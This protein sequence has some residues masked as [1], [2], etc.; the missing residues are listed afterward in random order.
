[1]PPRRHLLAVRGRVPV[2]VAHRL[3]PAGH[4]PGAVHGVRGLRGAELLRL[5]EPGRVRAACWENVRAVRGLRAR[6][7]A[8][9]APGVRAPDRGHA[10][11]HAHVPLGRTD[12]RGGL[13]L[14]R[15]R[16]VR[17]RHVCVS[18][19]GQLRRRQP[20][21]FAAKADEATDRGLEH[22]PVLH[23][24]A[25]PGLAADRKVAPNL[26]RGEL[27]GRGAHLLHER[28]EQRV[29]CSKRHDRGEHARGDLHQL[30]VRLLVHDF[31]RVPENRDGG[32]I[33]HLRAANDHPGVERPRVGVLERKRNGRILEPH[34]G[35]EER[36]RA[37]EHEQRPAL[38]RRQPN[39]KAR[40]FM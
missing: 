4:L 6:V 40:V 18:V 11:G 29:R 22:L 20:V 26:H 8:D 19:R 38:H 27:D 31:L 13:P 2:G 5:R 7:R 35:L 37:A 30:R 25:G 23:P 9:G 34:A 21:R 10:G 14:P 36:I 28:S 39:A 15:L 3:R 12:R 32:G 1:M 16:A 17:G 33:D 24:G